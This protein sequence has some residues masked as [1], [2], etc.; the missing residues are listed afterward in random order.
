M[1]KVLFILLA[2]FT[3]MVTTN[4]YAIE[5][6]Q[7]GETVTQEGEYD[8]LRLV[9][10]YNITNKAKVNGLNLIAGNQL[11]L[12]GTSEYGLYA[13][14]IINI[15]ESITKDLF[16]AGN[17]ITI[18]A[19]AELGRDVYIA[20]NTVTILSNIQRDLRV[21]AEV[22]NLTGVTING[23]AYIE[24]E[25]ITMDEKTVINGKLVYPETATVFGLDNATVG[26]IEKTKI[27]ITYEEPTLK[28]IIV[29][30]LV[31]YVAAVITLLVLLLVLP[32]AKEKLNNINLNGQNIVFTSLIGFIVLTIVPIVTLLTIFTGILTPVALILLA[33]YLISLY[34]SQI[35]V[36]YIIGNVITKKL[37]NK[38][39]MFIGV[40]FGVLI[41]KLVKLIPALGDLIGA[42]ALVYG[43]GLIYKFIANREKKN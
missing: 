2:I 23:D 15:R 11:T 40:L 7:F 29:D 19:G 9:A 8:S 27:E 3:F 16:V 30:F 26:S 25:K 13:G 28:D 5:L 31:S 42:L 38:E 1:K 37:F 43:L 20:G 17:S 39:T 6:S 34:L 24:A 12:E 4:V 36:A 33:V 14:N 21:G 32:K 35:I 18:L 10:G 22:V 41:I